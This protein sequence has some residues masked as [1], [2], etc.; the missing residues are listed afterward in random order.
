MSLG[1][2]IRSLRTGKSLSQNDLAE[3]LHVSRQSVSKWETNG[4]VPDLD[5]LI[6]MSEIFGVTLDAIV[7]GTPSAQDALSQNVPSQEYMLDEDQAPVRP[8]TMLQEPSFCASV[9]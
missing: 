9:R 1:E 5:K 2:R 4:S 3:S 8:P 6:S 7:K